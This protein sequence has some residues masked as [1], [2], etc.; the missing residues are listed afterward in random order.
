VRQRSG[1]LFHR[2]VFIHAVGI[3]NI[4]ILHAHALQ[5]LVETGEQVFA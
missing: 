1:S 5:A 4:N 3:E 2:R